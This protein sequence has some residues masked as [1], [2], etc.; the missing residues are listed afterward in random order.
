MHFCI[1]PGPPGA[2][3]F[4]GM[5]NKEKAMRHTLIALAAIFPLACSGTDP[6]PAPGHTHA[7]ADQA[8]FPPGHP[9]TNQML[10]GNTGEQ[11]GATDDGAFRTECAYSHM[12]YDDPIV[13]PGQ[14]GAAHL[15][16]F[17]GNKGTDAHS[18]YNSLRTSGRSTCKGG[19]VNRSAYW[20][21]TLL[22]EGGQPK[23]PDWSIFY[24]KQGYQI[25]DPNAINRI[26]NGLRMIAGSANK[27]AP[28]GFA[29]HAYWTCEGTNVG[30]HEGIVD[31]PVG[32][33]ILMT[34]V[35]PQCWNGRDIDSPDHKSHMAYPEDQ[36]CPASHPVAI[37]VISLNVG[38]RRTS[39][40]NVSA[41]KISSDHYDTSRQRPGLS[42]HGDWFDG[43]EP[44]IKDTFV[45]HCVRRQVDCHAH[46]LGDGRELL[47]P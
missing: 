3:S 10:I 30:H 1:L 35:F 18:T 31:C 29:E 15:H 32:D 11:P 2:F 36:A 40:M 46:L 42:V 21:P 19:I 27:T 26:P 41:L 28:V 7:L 13:F 24:Y 38:W 44:A 45:D 25:R 9:G 33:L 39:G 17:F 6:D 47:G 16:T 8:T 4:V 34:V 12:S 14:P 5:L 43:W 23:A 20:I 22:D 37:P